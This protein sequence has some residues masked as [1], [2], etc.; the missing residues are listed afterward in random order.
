VAA[1][2]LAAW[3]EREAL[4]A[5]RPRQW[6]ARDTALVELA[7][8]LP[9]TLDELRRIDALPAGLLKRSGKDILAAV[10]ASASQDSDCMPPRRPDENQKTLL[11][12]MQRRVAEC[13]ADLGLAAETLAS[14]RDL[15][16]VITGEGRDSKILSGWRRRLI[17]EQL[18]ALL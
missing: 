14:R 16:A 4:R 9:S 1:S 18:L 7:T 10:A 5:N 3:R 2:H 15:S 17:G 8:R 13:A 12:V 11:K 6:I